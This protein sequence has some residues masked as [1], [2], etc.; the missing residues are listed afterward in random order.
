MQNLLVSISCIRR[1]KSLN[2]SLDQ[3]SGKISRDKT[4]K[5]N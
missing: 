5:V 3:T 1:N 4:I 2:G